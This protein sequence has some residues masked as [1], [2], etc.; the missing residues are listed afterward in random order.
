[1]DALFRL[2]VFSYITWLPPE[3]T[4]AKAFIVLRLRASVFVDEMTV[5]AEVPTNILVSDL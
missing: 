3:F 2:T 5:E 4:V 1:M